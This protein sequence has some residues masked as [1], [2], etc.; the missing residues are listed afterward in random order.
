MPWSNGFDEWQKFQRM[1][2]E[3]T[4]NTYESISCSQGSL[5]FKTHITANVCLHLMDCVEAVLISSES[6]TADIYSHITNL[7]RNA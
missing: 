5:K 1:A 7:C 2:E 3:N 6:H 4:Y